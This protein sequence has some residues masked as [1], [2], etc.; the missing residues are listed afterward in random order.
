MIINGLNV[1]NFTVA[2]DE[3]EAGN[4]PE[5]AACG[6]NIRH[7]TQINGVNYGVRCGEKVLGTVK[8]ETTQ[9]EVIVTAPSMT[10]ERLREIAKAWK[11]TPMNAY[12]NAIVK[13][14]IIDLYIELAAVHF[15]GK[16][17]GAERSY[18]GGIRI[19]EARLNDPST[20][21]RLRPGMELLLEARSL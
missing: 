4:C 6:R 2:K 9:T 14:E 13:S 12:R 5:C 18:A 21:D 19:L 15:G 1:K 10:I 11:S 16:L 8:V 7:V 3:F 20:P 17:I